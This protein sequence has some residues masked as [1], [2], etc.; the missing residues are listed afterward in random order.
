[1]SRALRTIGI[2]VLAA[3]TLHASAG[4]CLCHTGPVTGRSAAP[5]GHACC[6]GPQ[7]TGGPAIGG[8]PTCCHIEAAQRDMTPVAAA[9]LAA[10]IAVAACLVDATASGTTGA[11]APASTVSASPPFRILRV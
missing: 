10:P 6:H 4:L 11:L 8:V 7:P 2:A 3:A 1:M 5:A 9:P